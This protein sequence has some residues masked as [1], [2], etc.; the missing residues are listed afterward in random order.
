PAHDIG[1]RAR[2]VRPERVGLLLGEI[3]HDGG[4]LPELEIAVDQRGRASS[5]IERQVVAL[6]LRPF[7]Q[8]DEDDIER[9]PEMVRGGEHFPGIGRWGKAIELHGRLVL[10]VMMIGR[11]QPNSAASLSSVS[12]Q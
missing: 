9:D 7:G 5:G 11:S 10:Y 2:I 12:V 8:I 4:R 1:A 6:T 3:L